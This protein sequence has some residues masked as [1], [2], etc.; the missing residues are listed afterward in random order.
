[1]NLQP[2]HLCW[3]LPHQLWLLL[4]FLQH[5]GPV[6]GRQANGC[7]ILCDNKLIAKF[8]SD[9]SLPDCIREAPGSNLSQ[10]IKYPD[11][12]RVFSSGS[13][14]EFQEC[15]LNYTKTTKFY[16]ISNSLSST[17]TTL[18][19]RDTVV[20]VV[21]RDDPEYESLQ[22]QRVIFFPN[23]PDLPSLRPNHPPPASHPIQQVL[24]SSNAKQRQKREVNYPPSSSEGWRMSGDI[25]LLSY[26][27]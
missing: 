18:G 7:Y 15:S 25:P 9:I 19:N 12:F 27:P 26:T 5:Y 20:G 4:S 16:N 2:V 1:M 6:T 3:I 17:D 23:L 22:I 13:P 11:V 24:E 21:L 8:G 10:D 14:E